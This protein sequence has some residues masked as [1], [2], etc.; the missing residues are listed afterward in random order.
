MSELIAFVTMH[1]L[2]PTAAFAAW[3]EYR[4]R[5]PAMLAVTVAG[6]AIAGLGLLFGQP[7]L[8]LVGLLLLCPTVLAMRRDFRDEDR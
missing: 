4:K 3:N 6:S 7:G 8:G 1:L 2:P 5:R